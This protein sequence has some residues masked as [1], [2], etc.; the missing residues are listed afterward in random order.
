MKKNKPNMK[1]KITLS[2]SLLAMLCAM[3]L[4]AAS[5]GQLRIS[6][7]YGA[8]G[9]SGATYNRDFVEI[10][11][12]TAS[13]ITVTNYAVQYASATGSS[14]QVQAFSA[15]INPGKYFLIA[16]GSGANGSALPTP[17]VSGGIA[18]AATAGKLALTSTN[19]ALTGVCPTGGTIVDFVG[20]GTTAN[21]FEGAGPT[22]APSTSRSAEEATDHVD[23][24]L[25]RHRGVDRGPE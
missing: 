9:N 11:N 12:P 17:D 8:G 16:L 15:T 3:L 25:P 19:T 22:P 13:P 24:D 1:H 10:F 20:F 14:W 6:Q 4:S 23:P 5:F 2:K 21:C 18:M 7:V